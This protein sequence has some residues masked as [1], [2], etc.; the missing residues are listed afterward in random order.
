M[1]N[2]MI[3]IETLSTASTAAVLSI[4]AVEFDNAG[5]KG[6]TFY[7][8]IKMQTCITAGL[9]V[10][11]GTL[12][13]WLKQDEDARKEITRPSCGL[14]EALEH[15]KV[16]HSECCVQ[17]KGPN[18]WGNGAAFDIPIMENAYKSVGLRAPWKYHQVRC[19]RTLRAMFPS[20]KPPE[21]EGITYHNALDDA[22]YQVEW[23]KKIRNRKTN[24]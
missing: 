13:W 2:I 11:G 8:V 16:F 23:Y 14:R 22:L 3:D 21:I 5:E 18:I 15:F 12:E 4:G 24:K 1:R 10:D 17:G 7:K 6:E 20:V 19:F 9:T